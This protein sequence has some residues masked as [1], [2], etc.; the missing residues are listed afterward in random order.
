MNTGHQSI[1]C[2]LQRIKEQMPQL[3]Q[4]LEDRGLRRVDVQCPYTKRVQ[5]ETFGEQLQHLAG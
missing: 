1:L 5:G 2:L 4:A 3:K